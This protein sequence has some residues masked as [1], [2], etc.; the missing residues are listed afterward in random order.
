[1]EDAMLYYHDLLL[2]GI[3]FNFKT[4]RLLTFPPSKG[5]N[6]N[7]NTFHTMNL[8]VSLVNNMELFLVSIMFIEEKGNL[9]P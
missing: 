8:H 9:L 6:L 5:F 3:Q 7:T 4:V 1:M 2:R